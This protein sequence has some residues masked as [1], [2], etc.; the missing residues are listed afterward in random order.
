ML[1]GL[2]VELPRLANFAQ[3]DIF[4]LVLADGHVVRR[5]IGDAR[6][7]LAQPRVDEALGRLPVLDDVF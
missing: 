3:F 1:L 7:K 4:P 5:H 6:Q 2:E